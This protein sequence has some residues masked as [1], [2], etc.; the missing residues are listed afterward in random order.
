M[1]A[2]TI[3]MIKLKQI[4]LLHQKG[5]SYRNIARVVGISKNTVKKY[6]RTAH[7]KGDQ[8]QDLALK[9]DYELEKIFAEPA[10]E[11]RDRNLDLL[12]FFP[13]M[14]KSLKETGVNRWLL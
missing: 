4:F 11:S 7:L 3:S 6:I 1:A 10:I 14:D 9:E 8:V 12:P 13:Y 2:D 5:E